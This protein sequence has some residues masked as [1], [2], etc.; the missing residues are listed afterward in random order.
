MTLP[1]DDGSA[2][3]VLKTDGSG[4]L[5]WVDQTTDTNT[6]YSAGT[7]LTLTGTTFSVDT[8]N[9]NTTGSAATLTTPRAI[10]SVNFDGSA[11]ITIFD[12]TTLPHTGGTLTGAVTVDA[13]TD[14]VYAITDNNSATLDPDNGMVQTWTLGAARDISASGDAL[15][16][17]QS[18]L[19]VVTPA[20]NS[21]TLPAITWAGG[22][23]PTFHASKPTAIEFWKIGSTLYA[24]S[25]GD[26]G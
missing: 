16:A 2:N 21:L 19:L 20:G 23:A 1:N 25:I 26:L 6:T 8:L 9:Q 5:S 4:G 24:A 15:T 14:T 10:N 17:G 22:S 18:M 7:G 12:A 13:I 11:D 3:Q